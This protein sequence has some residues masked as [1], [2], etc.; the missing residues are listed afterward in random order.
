[1][2]KKTLV[3]LAVM[4]LLLAVGCTQV[5]VAAQREEPVVP[6]TAASLDLIATATPATPM[7]T[8]AEPGKAS[9]NTEPESDIEIR[10]INQTWAS[11][12]EVKIGN[13]YPGARA[14]WEI[15]IHNG[16][17]IWTEFFVSYMVSDEKREGYALAPV[18]AK[19]WVIIEDSTPVLAPKETKKILVV[20][21][22][23]EGV[24]VPDKKWE[25]WTV[26]GEVSARAVQIQMATRWLVS[27]R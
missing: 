12:A 15:K 10:L 6:K 19:D 18:E 2:L 1:M 27:C 8:E 22:I 14:E 7:P 25:F 24:A 17:D 20:L 4:G 13:F 5:P 23:P 21:Y 26:A 9:F 11:P 3:T 16:N